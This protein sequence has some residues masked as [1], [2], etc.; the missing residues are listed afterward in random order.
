MAP[1]ENVV[2]CRAP[3]RLLTTS[4]SRDQGRSPIQPPAELDGVGGGP[5]GGELDGGRSSKRG[6]GPQLPRQAITFTRLV[7]DAGGVARETEWASAKNR[8]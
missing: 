3:N 7:D 8:K 2:A 5:A 4:H 6:S 1:R